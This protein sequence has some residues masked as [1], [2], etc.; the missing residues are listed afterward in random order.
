M[1]QNIGFSPL[2][3]FPKEGR[4]GD[5]IPFYWQGEYHVFYLLWDLEPTCSWEHIVSTDLI[6]WEE[7]PTML[8]SDPNDPE[9]PD[10]FHMFTGCVTEHEGTFYIHY[11]GHN[12]NNPEGDQFIC[13]ATS[14]DLITCRKHPEYAFTGDNIRYLERDFRDPYVFWNPEEDMWWMLLTTCDAKKDL[15]V[16]GVARSHDLIHWEQT[17]PLVYDPPLTD[18]HTVTSECPDLIRIGMDWHLL[19]T[20]VTQNIR[21]SNHLRGPYRLVEPV[22]ID[23]PRL[24]AG[25]RMFDGRRHIYFGPLSGDKE[26]TVMGIRELYGGPAGELFSRPVHEVIDVFSREVV[27]ISEQLSINGPDG[28]WRCEAPESYMAEITFTASSEAVLSFVFRQDNKTG[29][30][31]RFNLRISTQEIEMDG[32]IRSIVVDEDRPIVLR[33]FVQGTVVEC[34]LNDRYTMSDRNYSIHQQAGVEVIQ[35][36]VQIQHIVIKAQK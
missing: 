33:A 29:D 21:R 36:E 31:C 10:G 18:G 8:K 12:P 32:C 24:L 2:H 15:A 35:G 11:T 4:L 13:L 22:A 23:T 27:Q 34:F 14:Q 26:D 17:D 9:G 7:R 6:H 16:Q 30:G 19:Y 1:S 20:R 5:T 28:L 3:F 25:K